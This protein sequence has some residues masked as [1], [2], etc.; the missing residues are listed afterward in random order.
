MDVKENLPTSNAED[1][2]DPFDLDIR[3]YSLS[4]EER[5]DQDDLNTTPNGTSAGTCG[6][7]PGCM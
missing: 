3:L 7:S 1:L 4:D 2:D 6:R 5:N